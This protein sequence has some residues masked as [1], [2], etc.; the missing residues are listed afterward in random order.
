M[1][2][3]RVEETKYPN[4]GDGR[5]GHVVACIEDADA[6]TLQGLL[7]VALLDFQLSPQAYRLM[8]VNCSGRPGAWLGVITLEH[9]SS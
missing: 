1:T 6:V 3:L 2:F 9:V 8:S 5:I 7:N 4:V